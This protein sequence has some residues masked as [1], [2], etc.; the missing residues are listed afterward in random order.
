MQPSNSTCNGEMLALVFSASIKP[1][2]LSKIL[3]YHCPEKIDSFVK[4]LIS[5]FFVWQQ[6]PY[7]F[8]KPHIEINI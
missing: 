4:I 6:S 2:K 8:I 3:S 1:S 5:S 7:F